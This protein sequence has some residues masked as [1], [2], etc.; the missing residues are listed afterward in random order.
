MFVEVE[1][2]PV[3]KLT[4][5]FHENQEE[6]GEKRACRA[7]MGSGTTS[8][9]EKAAAKKLVQKPWFSVTQQACLGL[10]RKGSRRIIPMAEEEA[11]LQERMS[12]AASETL[13]SFYQALG[14]GLGSK[15][16]DE[17]GIVDLTGNSLDGDDEVVLWEGGGL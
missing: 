9:A 15:S 11:S 10:G 13:D 16:V 2:T 8:K 1:A 7:R 4:N 5:Q 14:D 3:G 6:G 17:L 12:R